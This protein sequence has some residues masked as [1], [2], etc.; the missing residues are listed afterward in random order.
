MHLP[1]LLLCFRSSSLIF[2]SAPCQIKYW[3]RG[4][5]KERE[6]KGFSVVC[7]FFP[8]QVSDTYLKSSVCRGQ[9]HTN[10]GGRSARTHCFWSLASIYFEAPPPNQTV[11]ASNSVIHF[12]FKYGTRSYWAVLNYLHACEIILK[13]GIQDKECHVQFSLQLKVQST[14]SSKILS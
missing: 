2:L 4:R 8:P 9:S 7:F 3:G 14:S 11:R 13:H 12:S 5:G 1:F 6:K 10:L